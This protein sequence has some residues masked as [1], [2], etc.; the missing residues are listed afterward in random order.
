MNWRTFDNP[1]RK[2]RTETRGGVDFVYWLGPG[3]I[4]PYSV[5]FFVQRGGTEPI[6]VDQAGNAFR[7]GKVECGSS[8]AAVGEIFPNNPTLPAMLTATV[9]GSGDWLGVSNAS[10]IRPDC[11]PLISVNIEEVER[12]ADE[13]KTLTTNKMVHDYSQA[14][15]RAWNARFTDKYWFPQL[16][17]GATIQRLVQITVDQIIN[18]FEG[19]QYIKD[20]KRAGLLS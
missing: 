17:D 16:V 19:Y 10:E 5:P 6:A 14:L 18:N 11:S 3:G 1:S 12:L 4:W 7:G 2:Y 20:L 9:T 13:A 8:I 15:N